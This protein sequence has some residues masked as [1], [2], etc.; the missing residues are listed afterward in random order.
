MRAEVVV[1][2]AILC[3]CAAE[4]VNAQSGGASVWDGVYTAAQAE[5]GASTYANHCTECHGAGLDGT[6]E[7]PALSGPEFLSH[8]DGRPVGALFDR[9]RK[10]MPND[11]P[12]SLKR[13]DYSD[14]IAFMLKFNGFPAG[15]KELDYRSEYLQG[16]EFHATK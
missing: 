12:G 1:V 3:A 6:G 5:R 4:A 8:Y 9:T 10:T 2:A 15:E 11:A 14:V 16:I 13:N 7:A